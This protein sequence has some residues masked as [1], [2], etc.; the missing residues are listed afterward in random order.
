MKL[1]AGSLPRFRERLLAVTP[2]ARPGWGRMTPAPLMAHLRRTV[3]LSLGEIEAEDVS[4]V[5]TRTLVKWI[6]FRTPLPWPRGKI[7]ATPVFL[8]APEGDLDAERDRLLAAI[9][10]FLVAAAAT[11]SARRL[12]PLFGSLRLSFWRRVHGRHFDHHLRQ[13]AV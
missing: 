13:F 12:H 3:E 6:A 7:R 11:P 2:D 4:N 10:R 1:S 5:L 9:D 8:P